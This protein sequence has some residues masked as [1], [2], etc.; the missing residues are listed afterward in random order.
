MMTEQNESMMEPWSEE[1]LR[2]KVGQVCSIRDISFDKAVLCP[3]LHPG[4][5]RFL[6]SSFW[7]AVCLAAG[8]SK[9]RLIHPVTGCFKSRDEIGALISS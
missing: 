9:S 5:H 1:E 3:E 6:V 2:T 7:P 8:L 4:L